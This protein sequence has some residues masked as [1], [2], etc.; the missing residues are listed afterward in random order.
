[1]ALSIRSPRF[2]VKLETESLILSIV[3]STPSKVFSISLPKSTNGISLIF[4]PSRFKPF[5]AMFIADIKRLIKNCTI[6]TKFVKINLTTLTKPFTTSRILPTTIE[7]TV[8]TI[9]R[10]F[11]IAGFRI[12]LK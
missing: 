4:A 3:F 12:S 5:I 6:L 11:T 8:A 2:S 1:L 9:L 10:K 7:M